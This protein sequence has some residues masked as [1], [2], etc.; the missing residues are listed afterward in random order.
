MPNSRFLFTFILFMNQL[1]F[2]EL[3]ESEEKKD[4]DEILM[5]L[6]L[7]E[8]TIIELYFYQN[9]STVQISQQLNCSTN[10]VK[11]KLRSGILF[12]QDRLNPSRYDKAKKIL[13]TNLPNRISY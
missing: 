1:I 3:F 5:R 2:S 11:R 6:P 12:F 9:L 4:L 7:E 10:I 8:R 13:Y